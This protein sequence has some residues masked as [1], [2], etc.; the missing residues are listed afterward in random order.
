MISYG[1]VYAAVFVAKSVPQENP[2][3]EGFIDG[4][5][6]ALDAVNEAKGIKPD[7]GNSMPA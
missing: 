2:V 5:R 3:V 4:G 7:G 6:A 1:I